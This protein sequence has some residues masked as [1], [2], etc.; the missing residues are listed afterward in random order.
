[1]FNGLLYKQIDSLVMG[2]PLRPSFA[3]AILSYHEENWLTNCPQGFKP[4]FYPRYVDYFFILFK[5]NDKLMYFQDFLNS[6]HINRSFYMINR[7]REQIIFSRHCN[8]T[9][10]R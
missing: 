3:N 2:S 4:V 6:F 9:R 5:S 8:H 7:K 1:M 10:G